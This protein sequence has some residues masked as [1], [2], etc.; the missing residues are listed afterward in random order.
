[1]PQNEYVE[2]F[3]KRYGRR[4]DYERRMR[5]KAARQPSKDSELIH[6]LHGLRA[7]LVSEKRRLEKI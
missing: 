1:M 2:L 5:K 4:F 3:Q 7:K 6:K